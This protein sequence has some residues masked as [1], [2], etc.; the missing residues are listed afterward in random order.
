MEC[1][2]EKICFHSVALIQKGIAS[3]VRTQLE[4]KKKQKD[5]ENEDSQKPEKDE[6]TNATEVEGEAVDKVEGEV[7]EKVEGEIVNKVENEVA[8]KVNGVEGKES[9]EQEVTI[10]FGLSEGKG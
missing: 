2:V 10:Y 8:E 3:I 5:A 4:T 7:A 6:V 9:N 1:R